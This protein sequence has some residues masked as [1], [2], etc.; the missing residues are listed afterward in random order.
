[1]KHQYASHFTGGGGFTRTGRKR[2]CF[3]M[4]FDTSNLSQYLKDH[5]TVWPE[6]Q[7]AL[8]ECRWHNYSLFYRS[9]GFAIGF[10]ETENNNHQESCDRMSQYD[11]NT[12]WQNMMSKYTP[13]NVR[14]DEETSTLEHF[15]YVGND[16]VFK[17]LCDSAISGEDFW[18]SQK[19]TGGGSLTKEGRKRICFQFQI[20][21]IQL[22]QYLEDHKTVSPEIQKALTLCGWHNYSLFYRPDGLIIGYYETENSSHQESLYK[23]KTC[24]VWRDIMAKHK[25]IFNQFDSST[26]LTEYFY[27]GNDVMRANI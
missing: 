9:D 7:K 8:V 11:V 26:L 4:K 23:I 24:D 1:M 19:Y 13:S 2:I 5:E 10:Y 15:F 21:Q 22:P 16:R 25:T 17:K 14:P 12:R 20:D 3:Q 6:M 18:Q 27:L